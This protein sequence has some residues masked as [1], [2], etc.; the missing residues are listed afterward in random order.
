[1]RKLLAST[2]LLALI[3]TGAIA[4]G[5][6]DTGGYGN[7]S[8]PAVSGLNA[9]LEG[10]G[11]EYADESLGAVAGSISF[12]LSHHYGVQIDGMAGS[13]GGDGIWG[14]GAHLFWRDPSRG[15]LGVYGDYVH[16]EA[17]G[18]NQVSRL[19]VEGELYHG[20]F[21]LEGM[22]GAEFGELEDRFFARTNLA[23]ILTKT[24]VC[25]WAPLLGDEMPSR[26]V[27]NGRWRHAVSRSLPRPRSAT[28][29]SATR[30]WAACASTSAIRT[31]A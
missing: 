12:P 4:G 18:G 1:M 30:S 2:A 20:R 28:T 24:C 27:R 15:L 22:A 16:W 11:G 9:K 8:L 26:W 31:R 13:S 7:P 19:A 14:V 25:S 21:S 10:F 29:T 3:A 5:L 23:F 6:K 17:F